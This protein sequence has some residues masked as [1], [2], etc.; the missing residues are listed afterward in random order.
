LLTGGYLQGGQT[1]LL[2]GEYDAAISLLEDSYAL[3]P[4][5]PNAFA[6]LFPASELSLTHALRGDVED[7]VRWLA[8]VQEAPQLAGM[9]ASL[10]K[11]AAFIAQVLLAVDELDSGQASKA[12]DSLAPGPLNDEFWAFRIHAKTAFALG[13]GDR[14]GMLDELRQTRATHPSFEELRRSGG[15]ADPLLAA[16]EA[17]LLLSMRHGN[18]AWAVVNYNAN[19]HPA[20]Q[21]AR[22]RVAV[23]AGDAAGGLEIVQSVAAADPATALDLMLVRALALLR[24]GRQTEAIETFAAAVEQC[25]PRRV[26]AFAAV[27]RADLVALIEQTPTAARLLTEDVLARLPDLYPAGVA[28]LHLTPQEHLV[29]VALVDGK[30]IDELAAEL[31]LA[32]STMK[33][34]RRNLYRKLAV[35]SRDAAVLAAHELGLVGP[36]DEHH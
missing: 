29:L 36:L 5:G 2:R 27:P 32:P 3:G 21:V 26:F 22:A 1:R 4:L 35:N 19:R 31:H 18:Q 12:L 9:L 34:H 20:L 7:A 6:P 10:I 23:L 28:V 16:A 14:T 8:R 15:V 13:W 11:P 33:S 24:L 17:N 25:G 30:T